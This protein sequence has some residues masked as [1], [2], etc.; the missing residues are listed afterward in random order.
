MSSEPSV[1]KVG[2]V[3]SRI[4]GLFYRAVDPAHQYRALLGSRLAGRY[5]E[6]SQPTLYLSS[7]PQGVDAAMIAHTRG[8]V[9]ELI[10]LEFHVEAHNIVDLRDPA[11]LLATGI[12]L[13][14]AVAPWQEIVKAGGE[15]S[16]WHV[17]R[18]LAG[19]S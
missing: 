1:E 18:R 7:S 8:R 9:A 10:L 15:P 11:V 4:S 14:D 12:D 2:D 13:A 16:S 5:S 17:R 3:W 6:P 19:V